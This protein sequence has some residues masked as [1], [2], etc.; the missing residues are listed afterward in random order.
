MGSQTKLDSPTSLTDV[1]KA[2]LFFFWEWPLDFWWPH[3]SDWRADAVFSI[4]MGA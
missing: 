2:V 3:M 4:N 1:L